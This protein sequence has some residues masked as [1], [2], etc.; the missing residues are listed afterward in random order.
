MVYYY[1]YYYWSNRNQ[2]VS[3]SSSRDI[4]RLEKIN[5]GDDKAKLFSDHLI[6]WHDNKKI[7]TLQ[8]RSQNRKNNPIITAL[9]FIMGIIHLQ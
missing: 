4:D 2:L 5:F 8:I 3:R 1:Y 6:L 7:S 9:S